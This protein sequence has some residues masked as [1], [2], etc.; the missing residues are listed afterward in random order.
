[1]TEYPAILRSTVQS[2]RPPR[3]DLQVCSRRAALDG[4]S[5]DV[6]HGLG[7]HPKSLPPKHF[8]DARGSELF[9]R[10]CNTPEYYPTRTEQALLELHAESIVHQAHPSCIVELGSGSEHKIS[11]LLE[12]VEKTRGH[13]SYVP[14]DVSQSALEQSGQALI[15]KYP[16]L[17]VHAIVGDYE[18]DLESLPRLGPTLY[19]FLGGTIGNFEPDQA[20][21]FLS[22]IARQMRAG[23]YLLLGTDLVKH[24]S[25]LNR[26]YN[27]SQGV[28]A[29]FNKNVL[30]VINRCL[31]AN[32][33]LDAFEH[34]AYF[35][36]EQQQIEMYLESRR[37]QAV[38][39]GALDMV[40]E[41]AAGERILTEIS[42]KF[43][44]AGVRSMLAHG[45][46]RLHSWFQPDS[47][48]FGLSVAE[49]D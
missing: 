28:T 33:D 34:V 5:R 49:L 46:L 7:R 42:R 43:T 23:D 37:R 12:A 18:R 45:G 24:P 17:S 16:W 6:L 4:L 40:V 48:Y 47:G 39:I 14:F 15:D 32:F 8:Y 41:F 36:A 44:Q 13:C 11:I 19:V 30:R 26:A 35:N 29:A 20:A 31:D 3:F 25:I 38:R 27:D 1:M 9:E 10:I 22:G 2:A 21:R